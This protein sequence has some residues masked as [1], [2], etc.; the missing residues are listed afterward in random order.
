VGHGLALV[1]ADGGPDAGL[2]HISRSSA[3]ALAVGDRGFDVRCFALEA[4]GPTA[5]DGVAWKCVASLESTPDLAEAAVLVVDSY[6]LSE[7]GLA[8]VPDHVP[9]VVLQ[10]HATPPARAAL[11]VSAAS[12]PA[13]GGP[14]RL[15]GFE[16]ACLRP[17]FWAP[18][19]RTSFDGIRR[20]LVTTGGGDPTPGLGAALAAA[21]RDALPAAA[22]TLVRGPFARGDHPAGVSLLDAPDSLHGALVDT[23]LVV[24]AGGQTML[25]AAAVG[26][27]TIAVVAAD[28]QRQQAT[29]LAD[30]GAVRLLELP[31]GELAQTMREL[32]AAP[33]V[34]RRLARHAQAAIDGRGAHR[35]A[36][37][38][39]ALT[40]GRRGGL[41]TRSA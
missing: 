13:L 26:T 34:R 3:L 33:H 40:S 18:P 11:V 38:I 23:D 27:P 21:A 14:D 9:V 37:R 10:E 2:G 22:V 41:P 31:A 32:D 25:E 36:E 1:V 16:Y 7:D 4:P 28:N 29:R 24:T 5:R 8:A 15:C 20:V 35:V 12:D 17:A 30:L 6:R 19:A 39:A